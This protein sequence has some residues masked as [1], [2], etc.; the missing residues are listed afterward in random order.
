MLQQ[1]LKTLQFYISSY[2]FKIFSLFL[3]AFLQT[4]FSILCYHLHFSTATAENMNENN[5]LQISV[6]FRYCNKNTVNVANDLQQQNS[7]FHYIK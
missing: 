7:G 3:S 4:L 1:I 2:T 6:I 5:Y